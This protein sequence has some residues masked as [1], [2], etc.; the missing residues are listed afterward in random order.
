VLSEVLPGILHWSGRHPAHG[1]I[2]HSHYLTEQRVAIDPIAVDGLVP[3]LERAGGVEQILLTN[4]H[5]LRGSEELVAA[6]GAALR[7][8]RPGLHEFEGREAPMVIG[9]GWGEE[10]APG[11]TAH[12]VGSLAP[13]DG[14][15]HIAIGPGALAFA[16][17]VVADEQGLGFVPDSLMDDLARTKAGI[18]GS[19]RAL[20]D[21]EF[22]A[23]LMAH[24]PPIPAGGRGVLASFVDSPRTATLG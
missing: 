5:H 7:C 8:P 18:L 20:L 12:V 2:V 21:L 10:L 1:A 6:F 9:Y 13:D 17:S 15:L 16:D 4:R 22:D 24:G 23:I 3:A 19:V 14:A 11:V